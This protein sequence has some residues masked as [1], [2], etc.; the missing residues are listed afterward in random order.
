MNL[1]EQAIRNPGL[2]ARS[3][4]SRLHSNSLLRNSIYIMGTGVATS[5][6]GY[7][8]WIIAAH[9]YLP[10]DVGLASALISV[11]TLA[12][13]LANLG[14]G[15]TLVERL[16]RREAGYA[17]SLTLNAGLATGLLAGLLT[18]AITVVILPLFSPQFAIVENHG[19]YVFALVVGV[20]IMTVSILLDQAF[21]AERAAHNMLMRNAA[22]ALLKIP[23]MVLAVVLLAHVGALGILLSGVLAMAVVLIGGLVLVTR[24]GRAYRVAVRGIVGQVRSMLSSLT[25]HYFINLG[26]LVSMQLLPVFVT[27]RLSATDNAYFYTTSKLGDFFLSASAAVAVS[28]FAEGSHA[29]EDLPRKL[30][31]S[32]VIIGILL[33]P[34]MLF[35]FLGGY[36]LLLVF[37][38]NYAQHGLTVL[39]IDVVSTV[40]DAITSV[41]ISVLRVQKRLRRAAVLNLG[42][43]S[44]TLVLAWILLPPLNIA[45]ASW[46]YLIAQSVGSLAAFADM[47]SVRRSRRLMAAKSD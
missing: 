21:I 3:L 8:Y 27:I 30:R 17:W 2:L 16:P 6:A 42:M 43:A 13:T 14:I 7:F 41:Y 1:N 12:S 9:T 4:V 36:Y 31:S 45:G 39:R 46:A 19:G 44:L 28:L 35:C 47:I 26:G 25:G 29:A 33:V 34:T 15:S 24:L 38:P 20:P 23:L 37:G 5:V 22:V 32:V 18:G 10:A 40:P 11:M